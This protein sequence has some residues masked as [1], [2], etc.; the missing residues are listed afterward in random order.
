M[1]AKYCR[2]CGEKARVNGKY[3]HSCG[4]SLSPVVTVQQNKV[5]TNLKQVGRKSNH[6]SKKFKKVA[7]IGIPIIALVLLFLA[8]PISNAITFVSGEY[9]GDSAISDLANRAG[10]SYKGKVEFYS[11]KPELVTA[12]GLNEVCPN[13]TPNTIEYGCYVTGL[14]KIYI[15]DAKY[16]ELDSIEG[17][18][19][20]HELMHKIYAD[21]PPAQG[22]LVEIEAVLNKTQEPSITTIKEIIEKYP[23]DP[24]LRKNELHSFFSAVPSYHSSQTMNDYYSEYFSNRNNPY[25]AKNL[26]DAKIK[27][28][29]SSIELKRAELVTKLNNLDN[30]KAEYIDKI[31][32]YLP[33][34]IYYGDIRR[35]NQNVDALNKNGEIYNRDIE[36]YERDRASFNQSVDDYNEMLKSFLPSGSVLPTL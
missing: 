7:P 12:D 2:H 18:A 27:E 9:L 30:F 23:A 32:G 22:L 17:W 26:F 21:D 29:A 14:D 15:L 16:A 6:K 4:K 13:D 34:N 5:E 31:E 19:A 33:S 10:F 20:A 11:A 25:L 28:K 3:C 24:E 1:V 36:E 35:Y 8:N